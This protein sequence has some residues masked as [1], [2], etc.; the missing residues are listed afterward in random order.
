MQRLIIFLIRMKLRV[1]KLQQF[2]FENQ[3]SKTDTYYFTATKLLKI[4]GCSV[5]E[6]SVSMNWL[7]NDKC[8]I[9]KMKKEA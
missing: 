9:I 6:S 5:R 4:E 1:R 3:K 8:K 7:L 2:K